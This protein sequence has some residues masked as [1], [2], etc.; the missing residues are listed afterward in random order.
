MFIFASL[1]SQS[2]FSLFFR[3]NPT[4]LT[5]LKNMFT[6]SPP[7]MIEQYPIVLTNLLAMGP[8]IWQRLAWWERASGRHLSRR[9]LL[10][11][12]TCS[13][14]KP[15][16]LPKTTGD[17]CERLETS[18]ISKF[19][20][21]SVYHCFRFWFFSICLS[22]FGNVLFFCNIFSKFIFLFFFI[23]LLF[24]LFWTHCNN[25]NPLFT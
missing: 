23:Q 11:R 6:V 10:R 16:S 15:R 18:F 22:S 7:L 17:E 4:A 25:S 9:P 1:T 12:W 3:I 5:D 19:S 20:R 8:S 14:E 24:A 13:P 2:Y 21:P